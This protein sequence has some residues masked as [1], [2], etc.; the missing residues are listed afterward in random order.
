MAG[1]DVVD[2]RAAVLAGDL[3]HP[4]EVGLGPEHRVDVGADP[5]EVAVH[6]GR[7]PPAVEAACPLDRAGVDRPDADPLEGLPQ[8]GVGQRAEEGLSRTGDERERV[9]GEP[10]RRGLDRVLGVRV[11]V[12]VLP[13]APLTGEVARDQL[14][15]LQHR[16]A[17]QPA[18]VDVVGPHGLSGQVLAVRRHTAVAQPGTRP[19][20]AGT[21]GVERL[22]VGDLARLVLDRLVT[23]R[24]E[25]QLLGQLLGRGGGFVVHPSSG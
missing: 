4:A 14:G 15:V 12:G 8:G 13:H 19:E 6:A 23:G 18:D 20:L 10:D 9:G 5:V 7:Q 24:L 2:D 25:G 3:G 22:D 21:G 1:D 16:L 17:Q 11:G